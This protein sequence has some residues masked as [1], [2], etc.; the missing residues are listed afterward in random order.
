[1]QS[2]GRLDV[3]VHQI[4]LLGDS[5]IAHAADALAQTY[6]IWLVGHE[7]SVFLGQPA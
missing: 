7:L 1:M 5:P 2:F 4:A 3:A 6:R